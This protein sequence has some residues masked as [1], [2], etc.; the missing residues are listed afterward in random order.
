ML[1]SR[2][3]LGKC[4]SVIR[5]IN[6]PILIPKNSYLTRLIVLD[7]HERCRHLGVGTT[8]A[9]VRNAGYWIPKG[10]QCVRNN[11]LSC[12]ICRKINALSFKYPR[13]HD[14][15]SERV[16]FNRVYQH[17]GV[18]FTAHVFVKYRDE[19]VKMYI[20]LFTCLNVRCIHLELLPSMSSCHFI[21][22]FVRFSNL[23]GLPDV[24]YSDNASTFKHSMRI[25]AESC[26]DDDFEAYL[27]KNN[28]RHVTIPVYSA[29][30]AGAWERMIKCL[31]QALAKVVGRKRI[32]Y[33][34]LVTTLS[35]IQNAINSRP[36]YYLDSNDVSSKVITPNSFL[37]METGRSMVFGSVDHGDLP[38]CGP[39]D[40]VTV[41]Q[42]R[43]QRL[44]DLKEAWY[45]EY[46]TSLREAG[47]D[48]YQADWENIIKVGDLVL[49]QNPVKPRSHWS[50]G[51]VKEL[52]PGSDG[53]VRTVK[54]I[55][56]DKSEA[57]YSINMLYPME[58]S[59]TPIRE[60]GSATSHVPGGG[61]SKVGK[62]LPKR[63][64]AARCLQ[65]LKADN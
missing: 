18:D 23:Y 2:D 24:V 36:L 37:K 62:T 56:P 33:F 25:V 29:W 54:L 12:V 47:R 30:V 61:E 46:L 51:R 20:V 52:L 44:H 9:A 26:M 53:K 27:S 16:N 6:E 11:L 59:V 65:K 63:R 42:Q 55:R 31:K 49:V 41:L 58:L 22:A 1:R 48:L 10:R 8:L 39:E 45:E 19:L 64:A 50:L 4:S 57:I 35:D 5:D 32:D 38:G 3:R 40:L 21:Q 14:Y 17:A 13:P 34:E 60:V 7:L 15:P 43:D 28:V